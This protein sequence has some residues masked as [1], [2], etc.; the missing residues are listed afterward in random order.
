MNYEKLSR[1]LRYY[2][3]KNIIKKVSGQRL[4]Y[5]FVNLPFN[6]RNKK[7]KHVKEEPRTE[8]KPSPEPTRTQDENATPRHRERRPSVIKMSGKVSPPREPSPI[9]EE[10]TEE[11]QQIKEEH[12]DVERLSPPVVTSYGPIERINPTPVV[13]PM[14][15]N[16]Q[17]GLAHKLYSYHQYP[18][19]AYYARGVPLDLYRYH[20]YAVMQSPCCGRVN[21]AGIRPRSVIIR[22]SEHYPV[23]TTRSPPP[24]IKAEPVDVT[25]EAS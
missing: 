7:S 20:P 11:V 18:T 15:M 5:K 10:K 25:Q 2:Y 21:I 16:T 22:P 1:A 9:P 14:N 12:I 6:N 8:I 4:V 24:L 23:T 13:V 19:M 3:Q 17:N